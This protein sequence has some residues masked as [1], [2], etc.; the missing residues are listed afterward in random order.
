M[1][2]GDIIVVENKA[3]ELTSADV[4]QVL[5]YVNHIEG[6]NLLVDAQAVDGVLAG[7]GVGYRAEVRA[8]VEGIDTVTWAELGY[9][10]YIWQ[11]H[12]RTSP[13]REFL[14]GDPAI[15]RA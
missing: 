10:D 3:L 8:Q 6:S 2:V 14:G 12:N 9:S 11:G 15:N 13:I 1:Q 7:S 4:D 5:G